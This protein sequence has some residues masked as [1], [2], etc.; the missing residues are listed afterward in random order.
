MKTIASFH[1]LWS[2]RKTVFA[3]A[4]WTLALAGCTGSLSPQEVLQASQASLRDNRIDEFSLYLSSASREVFGLAH[5]VGNRYGYLDSETFMF[6][7][8]LE[9][10]EPSYHDGVAELPV[11][12]D[13]RSGVLCFV[14]EDGWKLELLRTSPCLTEPEPAEPAP[15]KFPQMGQPLSSSP[16]ED[17]LPPARSDHE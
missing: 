2:T 5:S 4:V 16:V 15:W 11:R 3:C 12:L 9:L 14:D 13:S 7:S 6:L 1:T 10:G 17:L 8:E